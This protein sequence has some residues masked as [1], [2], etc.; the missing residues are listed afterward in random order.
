[1]MKKQ[2]SSL[3]FNKKRTDDDPINTENLIDLEFTGS[4][5]P[6]SE[7]ITKTKDLTNQTPELSQTMNESSLPDSYQKIVQRVKE[8][9]SKGKELFSALNK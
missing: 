2:V 9:L 1:M 7:I 3:L 4:K 5:Q 6:S 8:I